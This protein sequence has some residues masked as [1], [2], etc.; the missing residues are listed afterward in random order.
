VSEDS[1]P[2]GA[3]VPESV[4]RDGAFPRLDADQ[5][6]RLRAL[7]GLRPVQ[8]GDVLFSAGDAATDFFVIE[9]GAVAIVQGAGREN[10]VI[11]VHGQH[12]F[13]GELGM[14]IGQRLYLSGIVRD[15]GEVIQVPLEELRR[16]VAQDKALS[17]VILGAFFARR[18]ILIDAGA[19]IRLIGSR[20]STDTRRLREF[21]ARNRMPH[22]WIDLE[23][24]ADAAAL[25]DALALRPD[26]TPVVIQGNGD[27]LRNPSNAELG[28]AMGLGSKVSP[29]ALCDVIVVGSGPAGLSAALY[30]ASEGLDVQTVEAVASGGQA[31]TSA[32]IENY[33]GFPAGVSGSELTQRAGVQAAKFGARLTVPAAAVGLNSERGRH[34][35]RLSNGEVMTGR[36]VVVATGAQYRRLDVPRL[37][38][39]EGGGVYYAATQAEAQVCTGDSVVVVGGGNSAGQAA[40]FLS[41][42]SSP[43]RLLIRGGD[44]GKSM[45]RYLVDQIERNVRIEVYRHSRVAE[46]DGDRE[47]QAIIVEN[48]RSGE[49]T[50]LEARALFVFIGASPHTEW[51]QDQ[52]ATDNAGFLLTGRDVQDQ[53][54]E[55]FNGERPLFLE[56]SRPGVFAVGDVHSGSIKRVASA[57]GEGS[58]AVRLIHQRLADHGPAHERKQPMTT[59]THLD[60]VH[61][62]NLPD[63]VQGCQD[64]LNTGDP[65]LHLRICLECGNVGCCDDSPNRH[66]TSHA[67]SSGHPIIRSLEPGEEW[68]WCFP[69]NFALLIPE[70]KGET[71]IPPSPL[72]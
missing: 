31:G 33:L 53:A 5:R 15:P 11:A 21:L 44:L 51:L 42:R 41:E 30:A 66:A 67:E 49:R 14:L 27:I 39:F 19:G 28:K 3:G 61:I 34:E 72:A 12:R 17:D 9:S 4:N 70:V 71:R 37:D 6:R 24:D 48:T 58:M 63:S 55:E 64:C 69:D 56:T 59:C 26:Q 8:S 43:C 29:P 65:W 13:L 25:L 38:E 22:E 20:F 10:R 1:L 7:G 68:S 47:L 16:I 57:V 50:R 18:S 2:M 45:S 46:V 32:R 52:L 23:E 35:I 36:T 54:L 40:M 62:T 60:H